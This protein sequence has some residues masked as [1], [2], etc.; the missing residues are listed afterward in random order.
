MGELWK[1]HWKFSHPIYVKILN[2][3]RSVSHNQQKTTPAIASNHQSR[4][5]VQFLT[6]STV[7]PLL[8]SLGQQDGRQDKGFLCSFASYSVN[9]ISSPAASFNPP[10][11][12]RVPTLHPSKYQS[13][14]NCIVRPTQFTRGSL[15]RFT[16]TASFSL[17][18]HFAEGNVVFRTWQPIRP[19][20]GKRFWAGPCS[21][22]DKDLP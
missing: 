5:A 3:M 2:P 12:V 9:W 11:V 18:G 7:C 20:Q 17:A 1:F 16:G 22:C 21:A 10:P 15:D 6:D 19:L 4:G 14:S 8:C 13:A